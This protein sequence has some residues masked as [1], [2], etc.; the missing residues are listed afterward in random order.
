MAVPDNLPAPVETELKLALEPAAV[1]R[2]RRSPLLRALKVGRGAKQ[3]LVSVYFDTADRKLLRHDLS[4]RVRQVGTKRIQ[5]L[6]AAAHAPLARHE[7]ECEVDGDVPD[8]ESLIAL[9]GVPPGGLDG[10]EV[11]QKVFATDVERTAW[12]LRLEDGSEVELA[13]DL[14]Q[15]STD[16]GSA[17]ICEAELELK[18]GAA[19]RLFE[20]AADLHRDVPFRVEGRAKSVRGYALAAGDPAPSARAVMPL[21][22]PGMDVEAAFKAIAW[23]CLRHLDLNESCAALGHDPEGVHQ[24]RVALRRLRSVFSLFRDNLPPDAADLVAELRWLAG[25]CGPARDWD[26]FIVQVLTPLRERLPREASLAR[27]AEAAVAERAT[28]YAAVR[29]ALAAPRTTIL[30][31]RLGQFLTAPWNLPAGTPALVAFADAVLRKRYRKL[32]ELGRRKAELGPEQLHAL[33]LLAKKQRYATEFFRGLYGKKAVRRHVQALMAVQ[34]VLGLMNDASVGA[35]LMDR[36]AAREPWFA[37]ARSLV[38]GWFAAQLHAE[39][40]HLPRVWN[41][42]AEQQRFWGKKPKVAIG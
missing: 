18:S 38:D 10:D 5:T 42:L 28:A 36:V 9:T 33:R 12:P 41:T 1:A 15:I 31:L 14:G 29:E 35:G 37:R 23:A 24:V 27:L 20:L 6:K 34:D 21:L 39:L 4:L 32:A 2:L 3:R 30:K 13:L 26:V 22:D 19:A 7:W 16:R 8:L 11:L 17:P 25:A 40:R